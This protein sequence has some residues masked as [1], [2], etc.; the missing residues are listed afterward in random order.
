MTAKPITACD[1]TAGN[2]LGMCGWV[3]QK[4]KNRVWP[5]LWKALVRSRVGLFYVYRN[6]ENSPITLYQGPLDPVF[7]AD[8][9]LALPGQLDYLFTN[10]TTLEVSLLACNL[11][12]LIKFCGICIL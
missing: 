4:G 11:L 3:H 7:K 6:I 9:Q 8:V 2:V 1:V 5:C 10:H 12:T